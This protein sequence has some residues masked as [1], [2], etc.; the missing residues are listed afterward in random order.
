MEIVRLQEKDIHTAL[1]LVWSVFQEF[2]APEYSDEGVEAFKKIISYETVIERFRREELHFWG[3]KMNG[4]WTGVIATMGEN[5][6]F[7]LFVK[8]EYHGQ[9]IAHKL[10]R[11]L[12][13][14]C[15]RLPDLKRITV[16]S[17]RYAL[18]FYRRLGFTETDIERIVNGIRFTPMELKY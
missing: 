11:T 3:S 4:D 1:E 16:N 18:P 6:I 8:R 17:S 12:E 5:H 10:F 2:E 14:R 13:E 7:L 15:R 9:G